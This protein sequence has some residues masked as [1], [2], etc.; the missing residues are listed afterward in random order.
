MGQWLGQQRN[1]QLN[2]R[3]LLNF[4]VHRVLVAMGAK[5]LE[6]Q[7]RSGVAAVLLGGV[8]RHARGTL[9]GVG[10]AL[11]AF[12]CDDKTNVFTFSHGEKLLGFDRC[13]GFAIGQ[14]C[15]ATTVSG[16][17]G[18]DRRSSRTVVLTRVTGLGSFAALYL[19]IKRSV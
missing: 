7:A 1:Q 5:F 9:I 19:R 15:A 16:W 6:F 18:S 12:E 2:G 4:A 3:S 8:A 13:K 17:A 14:S 10:A 11:G